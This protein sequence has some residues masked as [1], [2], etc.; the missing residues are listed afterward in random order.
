MAAGGGLPHFPHGHP[1]LPLP[2]HTSHMPTPASL[3]GLT[4]LTAAAAAASMGRPTSTP[5]TPSN[6]SGKFPRPNLLLILYKNVNLYR[7]VP[8]RFLGNGRNSPGVCQSFLE[9]SNFKPETLVACEEL[10]DTCAN[11]ES[12][13]ACQFAVLFW[14]CRETSLNCLCVVVV[15]VPC[16]TR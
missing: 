11:R 5:V 13:F 16:S 3:A 6:Y 7:F 1:G 8:S 9:M 10:V 2:P 14:D 12:D 15:V 4:G